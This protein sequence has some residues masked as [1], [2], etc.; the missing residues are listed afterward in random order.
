[1][2]IISDKLLS[3]LE[4]NLASRGIRKY[5][6]GNPI[7][8]GKSQMPLL[9]VQPLEER[10]SALDSA[11]DIKEIDF[12]IG[13]IADPAMEYKKSKE[14]FEEV[15]GE[16]F[17]MEIISGRNDNGTPMTDTISYILRNNWTMDNVVFYQESRT[18][19]GV[20]YGNEADN[21]FYKEV[22]YFITA[23]ASVNTV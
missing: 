16:R 22:H 23:K 8:I 9:F 19:Y 12:Q 7:D 14:G 10:V 20:R 18:V 2:N 21:T 6:L 1:M 17:L 11:H 15:A 4:A 13:V 3:I 5:Q